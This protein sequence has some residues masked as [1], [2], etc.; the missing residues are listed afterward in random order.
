ME[1]GIMSVNRPDFLQPRRIR[2]LRRFAH[3]NLDGRRN[4]NPVN[5][6]IRGRSFQQQRM[7]AGPILGHRALVAGTHRNRRDAFA[8]RAA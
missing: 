4:K 7:A 3:L 2:R 5:A 6:A 1:M 8:L